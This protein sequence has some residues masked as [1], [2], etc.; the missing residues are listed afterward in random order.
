LAIDAAN[1]SILS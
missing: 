1:A